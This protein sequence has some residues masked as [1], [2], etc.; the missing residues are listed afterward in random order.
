MRRMMHVQISPPITIG[1]KPVK[2]LGEWTEI[3]VPAEEFEADPRK[4][5]EQALALPTQ[6]ESRE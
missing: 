1:Q 6:K 4:V 3:V 5:V 2:P